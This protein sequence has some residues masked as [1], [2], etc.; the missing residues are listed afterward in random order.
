MCAAACAWTNGFAG[1]YERPKTIGAMGLDALQTRVATAL[2]IL[3]A[4]MDKL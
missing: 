4:L 3:A 2:W 1:R